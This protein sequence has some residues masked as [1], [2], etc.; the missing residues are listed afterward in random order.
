MAT[1][2]PTSLG[3]EAGSWSLC[4]F[5]KCFN[6]S[7]RDFFF[8]LL[9]PVSDT[10]FYTCACTNCLCE[11]KNGLKSEWKSLG[12]FIFLPVNGCIQDPEFL[13]AG[14]I[15]AKMP[16]WGAGSCC[17]PGRWEPRPQTL[18]RTRQMARARPLGRVLT[19][20]SFSLCFKATSKATGPVARGN[21]TQ[22]RK[23]W[24]LSAKNSCLREARS[25]G[26]RTSGQSLPT[27][28]SQPGPVSSRVK[29]RAG[30]KV[31]SSVSICLGSRAP[32][33]FS[34]RPGY[35]IRLQRHGVCG[36]PR[37]W[38]GSHQGTAGMLITH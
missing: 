8:N 24:H 27:D 32:F 18:L 10:S 21:E 22:P 36:F 17:P 30:E 34:H 28:P 35:E 2:P 4:Q 19:S 25:R 38:R 5:L 37:G 33:L 29:A 6:F 11:T 13:F 23:R 15:R 26:H 20:S 16:V 3:P 14:A 12:Y 7:V 9:T 1:L 31:E